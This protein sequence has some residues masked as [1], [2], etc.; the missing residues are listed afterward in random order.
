MNGAQFDKNN[1]NSKVCI[2]IEDF[3]QVQKGKI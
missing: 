1:E 3:H 2:T